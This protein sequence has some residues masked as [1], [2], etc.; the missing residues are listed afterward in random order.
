MIKIGTVLSCSID[1]VFHISD[2]HTLIYGL[3]RDQIKLLRFQSAL[4]C[5]GSGSTNM[6]PKCGPGGFLYS[7]AVSVQHEAWIRDG[8][9]TPL[10]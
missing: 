2:D 3:C 4:H 7:F 8:P 10:R 5:G 9:G 1:G 6:V